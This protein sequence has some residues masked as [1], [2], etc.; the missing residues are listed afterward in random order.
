VIPS[1]WGTRNQ[2]TASKLQAASNLQAILKIR[3]SFGIP[4]KDPGSAGIEAY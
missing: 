4:I 2:Q 3:E 1:A